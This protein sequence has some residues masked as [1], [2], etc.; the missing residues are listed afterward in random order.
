MGCKSVDISDGSFSTM[1]G[2]YGDNGT[3]YADGHA[4]HCI[5]RLH[6]TLGYDIS[7]LIRWDDLGI[8]VGSTVTAAS[9]TFTFTVWNSGATVVGSY[10]AVPWNANV[11]DPNGGTTNT[12]TGWRTRD[13]GVPWTSLGA[14]GEGSDLVANASFRLPQTGTL[15]GNGEETVSAPLD[16]AIVQTWV[17]NPASNHGIKL[18]VDIQA[19]HVGYVQPQREASRP[20][21]L[22]PLLSI[23]YLAP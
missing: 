8:P 11:E 13:T 15:G 2:S 19:V 10:V 14:T 9:V 6:S 3:V 18:Q 20:T 21:T 1:V 7:P 4:D 16:P 12:P 5:G 23:T 17:D 22:R